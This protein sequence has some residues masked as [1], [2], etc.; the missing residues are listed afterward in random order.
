MTC[1]LVIE[2]DSQI[3]EML[4]TLLTRAGYS[5]LAAANGREG[6]HI[7]REEPVDLVVTDILMPVQEG[8]ETITELKNRHPLVK[9]IAISGGGIVQPDDYLQMA[10]RFGAE[11]T[12]SKPFEPDDLLQALRFLESASH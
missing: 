1:V 3:R 6:M 4:E 5:V 8:I 9:V 12:I 7:V 11:M 10:E 2:D